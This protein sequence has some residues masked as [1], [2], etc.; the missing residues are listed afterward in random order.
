MFKVGY[1]VIYKGYAIDDLIYNNTYTISYI[2]Q[3]NFITLEDIHY[4]FHSDNFVKLSDERS[5][6]IK[7]ICSKKVI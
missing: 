1:K 6:K 5:K 2:T 3:L 7:K 4:V